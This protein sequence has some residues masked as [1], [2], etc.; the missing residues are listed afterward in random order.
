[1]SEKKDLVTIMREWLFEGEGTPK[2]EK[3]LDEKMQGKI[4]EKPETMPEEKT[5]EKAPYLP[6]ARRPKHTRR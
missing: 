4:E 6:H 3:A 2:D 1:M 5:E